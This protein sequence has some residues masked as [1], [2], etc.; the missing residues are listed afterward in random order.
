L[1]GEFR[2]AVGGVDQ[3]SGIWKITAR[4][5]N[6]TVVVT[7]LGLTTDAKITLHESWDWWFAFHDADRAAAI[8]GTH[9]RD[10]IARWRAPGPDGAGVVHAVDIYVPQG[11]LSAVYPA[12]AASRRPVH[13]MAESPQGTCTVF[14]I[15]MA[16]RGGLA[17][18]TK[19]VLIDGFTLANGSAL[20]ASAS[21]QEVTG[22]LAERLAHV[23]ARRTAAAESGGAGGEPWRSLVG[24]WD[25]GRTLRMW[26]MAGT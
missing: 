9:D 5:A 21:V 8:T 22:A 1:G 18:Q 26:D 3:H 15:I 10:A 4:R 20:L 19:G 24:E 17:A 14:H 6:S 16:T 13:W 7:C 11:E 12:D 2:F 25:D 23:R